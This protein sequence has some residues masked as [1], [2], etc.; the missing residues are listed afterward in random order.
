M[1]PNPQR[2]LLASVRRI[3]HTDPSTV[4][5]TEAMPVIDERTVPRV[6]DLATRIGEAMFAVGASA[7]EVTLAIIRVCDAYGMRGVQ[8]DVT[9]N[10]ITV[11]FHLRPP[12]RKPVA[13]KNVAAMPC[14]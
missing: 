1:S 4:A 11:S 8:V 2:R 7:H 9:Y 6:L 10:S 13:T 14:R 3:L 5:H 12:S